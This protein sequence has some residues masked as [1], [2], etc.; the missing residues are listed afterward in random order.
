MSGVT[1]KAIHRVSGEENGAQRSALVL[2]EEGGEDE[3]VT[4]DLVVGADG[5]KSVVRALIG[6]KDGSV[7]FEAH[8]GPSVPVA[9][10]L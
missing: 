8:E 10:L 7:T 1:C 4:A 6:G 2:S 9:L 3:I 5:L